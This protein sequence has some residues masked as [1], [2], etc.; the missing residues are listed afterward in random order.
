[1]GQLDVSKKAMPGGPLPTLDNV[2]LTPHMM[3][4]QSYL[5]RT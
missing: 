4:F 1:M 2:I 5:S 3:V